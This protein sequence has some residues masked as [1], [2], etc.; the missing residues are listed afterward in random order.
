MSPIFDWF[1]TK[2][3]TYVLG[4]EMFENRGYWLNIEDILILGGGGV[5]AYVFV[6]LKER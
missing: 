2:I 3:S 5:I 1:F 4:F 6:I